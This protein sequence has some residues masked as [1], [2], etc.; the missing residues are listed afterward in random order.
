MPEVPLFASER[1]RKP[2]RELRV[3]DIYD[4]NSGWRKLPRGTVFGTTVAS[5]LVAQG[6]TQVRLQ[7]GREKHE[8]S[9]LQ[10][11]SGAG[12]RENGTA[13]RGVSI[14]PE[15]SDVEA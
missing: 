9:I 7:S 14:W 4:P 2:F 5:E 1:F 11:S 12:R 13:R 15:M 8:V 3:T 6:V 10:A